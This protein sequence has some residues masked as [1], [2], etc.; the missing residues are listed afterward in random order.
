MVFLAFILPL[1]AKAGIFSLMSSLLTTNNDHLAINS[2][3]ETVQ[4]MALLEATNTLNPN[5][6]Y[7]QVDSQIVDNSS[8][9]AEAG[10]IGGASDVASSTSSV[11]SDQISIYTV[12]KGDTLSGIADMFNVSI[13]TILWAN[14]LKKG[15]PVHEGDSLVILPITG[16]RYT[17]KKGDTL[18]SI[19][20]K[21]GGDKGEIM[22]FN[23]LDSEKL[24]IGEVIIIPDG[25]AVIPTATSKTVVDKNG[26]KTVVDTKPNYSGYYIWP[27]SGGRKSQGLH[28]GNAIDIAAPAGTPILASA[29]GTVIL[30][31]EGGYNGGYGNYAV[32]KHSNGTQTLYAHALYLS[33][34]VGQKVSSGQVIGGVG[35]TGRSTGNH[36]HFEVRG[37]RNPF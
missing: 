36:L 32:I 2:Q 4:K 7:S 19:I 20:K 11:T 9:L 18:A 8:F 34:S 23:N 14:D 15:A 12:R 28:G 21:Y 29:A 22:I 16:L 30:V 25:D 31:R 35:N 13:N 37:A 24:V 17:V 27:V 5:E 3:T 26:K 33:V 10:P 1:S 6:S